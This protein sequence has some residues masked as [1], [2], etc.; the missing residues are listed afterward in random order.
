MH[1]MYI[2]TTFLPDRNST[3]SSIQHTWLPR[4]ILITSYTHPMHCLY[5]IFWKSLHT[6]TCSIHCPYTCTIPIAHFLSPFSIGCEPSHVPTMA[7][8]YTLFFSSFFQPIKSWHLDLSGPFWTFGLF[9]TFLELISGLFD[10]FQK[11][12]PHSILRT[13]SFDH[14]KF[15]SGRKVVYIYMRCMARC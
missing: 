8:C 12:R 1:L 10:I 11:H 3:C 4:A 5:F 2:Y 7:H 9:W 6:H 13:W 14:F 15:L